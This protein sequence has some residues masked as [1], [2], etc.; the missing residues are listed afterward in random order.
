MSLTKNTTMQLW[1]S[2]L[3]PFENVHIV[4]LR[5]LDILGNITKGTLQMLLNWDLEME[6]VSHV[7]TS[8][9]ITGRQRGSMKYKTI[10]LQKWGLEWCYHGLRKAEVSKLKESRNIFSPETSRRNQPCL[11]LEFS[12]LRFIIDFWPT[13][14]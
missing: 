12:P 2:E 5:T 1:K 8:D 4:V 14:L 13:E 9:L 7:N 11:H 10:C 3:W 6:W